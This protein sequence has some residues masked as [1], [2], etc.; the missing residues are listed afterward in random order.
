MSKIQNSIRQ[1]TTANDTI[2]QDRTK[3][4]NGGNEHGKERRNYQFKEN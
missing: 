1:Y 4:K 3:H 2:A